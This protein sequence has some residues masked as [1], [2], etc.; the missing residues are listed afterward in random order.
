MLSKILTGTAGASAAR[1]K[2]PSLGGAAGLGSTPRALPGGADGSATDAR[3]ARRIA[4]LE[5]QMERR[6]HE[7]REAGYREGEAA[8]RAQAATEVQQTVDGLARAVQEIAG[9][10]PQVMRDAGAELIELALGIARRILHREVSVD[11]GALEGLVS[12]ALQKLAGQEVL[13]IRVHPALEPGVRQA[14]AREGRGGLPLIADGTLERGA[15][16]MET[17][18]GKLDASLE[19]QLAEIGRGLADRL[20]ER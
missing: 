18:R 3:S 9:L 1:L 8:A 16:Q 19:T 10:R 11:P 4:E 13:R 5:Q 7:A 15:V 6:V 17:A 12:G 20:P 2:W 14:L